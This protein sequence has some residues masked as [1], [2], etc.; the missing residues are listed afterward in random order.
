MDL[1]SAILAA[2]PRAPEVAIQGMIDQSPKLRE[3]GALASNRRVAHLIGQ[4][5]HESMGFTRDTEGLYYRTAARLRQVWP[6]RF[7]TEASAQPYARNPE[8]LANNVYGGRMGN[9]APGDGYRYRG[10]GWIQLTG[11]SNYQKYGGLIGVDLVADPDRATDPGIAWDLAAAYMA[12]RTRHGKTLFVWADENNIEAVTRGINGGTHGLDD[13]KL[14]TLAALKALGGTAEDGPL[15]RGDEGGQ[16]SL[17]QRHLAAAGHSPGALDGDFGPKTEA[18]LRAF[19]KALGLVVTGLVDPDTWACLE[20]GE[21]PVEPDPTPAPEPA[22][23]A[24]APVTAAPI[25]APQPV[26]RRAAPGVAPQ[27]VA[28]PAAPVVAPHP[29]ARP[30][31]PGVAPQP[32][33]RPA[34]SQT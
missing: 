25:V 16:V 27:P 8:K 28:R 23:P 10:R 31:A 4:C 29:V 30:A 14:C 9:T 33:A 15:K 3:L 1:R 34:R 17:L 20:E 19:Q 22:S 24:P 21:A 18:A 7:P 12:T 32:V 11:K 5:A 26:A 2:A 13:R 6:S